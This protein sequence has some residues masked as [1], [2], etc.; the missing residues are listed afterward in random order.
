MLNQALGCVPFIPGYL[1]AMKKVCEEFGALIIV[2]EIMCGTGRSGTFHAWQQEEGFAPDIECLGKGL[3]GGLLP[4]SAVLASKEIDD[5]IFRG[6]GEFA[7]GHTHDGY[8]LGSAVGLEVVRI[9]RED[10][11]KMLENVRKMG[12]LLSTGL[13]KALADHRYVG[14]IRGLG[15]FWGVSDVSSCS[16]SQPRGEIIKTR[17]SL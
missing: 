16:L 17:S 5:T 12:K 7:H 14:D 15:L 4:V 11:G 6:P 9:L 10:N 1:K 2:D 8:P 13:K 3:G